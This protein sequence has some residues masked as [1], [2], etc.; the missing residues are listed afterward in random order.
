M[1]CP[2]FLMLAATNTV[3]FVIALMRFR[4]TIG[5]TLN[6]WL[7]GS[8]CCGGDVPIMLWRTAGASLRLLFLM[9]TPRQMPHQPGKWRVDQAFS[10]TSRR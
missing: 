6:A 2:Q 1:V 3:F 10:T 5:E 8:R 9:P 7:P 4:K